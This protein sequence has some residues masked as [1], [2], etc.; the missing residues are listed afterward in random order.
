MPSSQQ[1]E[2]KKK[3]FWK[4]CEIVQQESVFACYMLSDG[5]CLTLIKR[6]WLKPQFSLLI[7]KGP[8]CLHQQPFLE[9]QIRKAFYP[10]MR[11][12]EQLKQFLFIII[13]RCSLQFFHHLNK[14]NKKKER[15]KERNSHTNKTDKITNAFLIILSVICLLIL[16]SHSR[17]GRMSRAE[18][19][20]C[21]RITEKQS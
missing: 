19:L 14:K 21:I 12:W 17:K 20:E 4:S 7:P 11:S 15:G 13:H 5:K 1:E 16:G 10:E 6:R 8:E 3:I 18:V 9:L 2:D